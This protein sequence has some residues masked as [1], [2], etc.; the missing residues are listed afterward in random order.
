MY[1]HPGKK[2]NFMGNEFAQLREWDEKREQDWDMLRYP[3]HD[4]FW[5]FMKRLNHLYLETPALSA[6]DFDEKGFQW[7]DCHQ[8]EKCVYVFQRTDGKERVLCV[9]HFSDQMQSYQLKLP[10]A[11]RLRMMITNEWHEEPETLLEN[12]EVTLSLSPYCARYYKIV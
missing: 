3:N 10:K 5:R 4:D 9:F 8:E 6:L 1:A 11:K 7:I 2:L 12:G